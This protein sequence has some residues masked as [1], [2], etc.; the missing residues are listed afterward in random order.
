MTFVPS[1]EFLW[2]IAIRSIAFATVFAAMALAEGALP[3]RDRSFSR[4]ARWPANLAIAA[5]NGIAVRILVPLTA[6]G[7]ALAAQQR[8]YGLLNWVVPPGPIALVAAVIVLDLVIYLQHRAFH[9][10]P[11]LWRIH[12]V[13]HADLDFDVTTGLRFHPVEILLSM[14]IKIGTVLAIGASAGVVLVFEV[15]LNATS[16]F[17]HGNLKL[18]EATDRWLRRILVTPDMHRVHHSIVRTETNSNFGFNLP[19]WD[20]LMRTYCAQPAAGHVA[21][22]V[23]IDQFRLGEELNLMPMLTQPLR[24]EVGGTT[25]TKLPG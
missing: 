24:G 22:T 8:G 21:M 25:W 16:M 12:R 23:G 4:R 9:A 6:I 15:L 17:N 20:H 5:I 18:S 7:A 14:L 13:H 11:L 1:G 2:E 10:I 19:W 3:R